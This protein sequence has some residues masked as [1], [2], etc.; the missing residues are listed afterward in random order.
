[1]PS[2]ILSITAFGIHGRGL[3]IYWKYWLRGAMCWECWILVYNIRFEWIWSG[4][5]TTEKL[6]DAIVHY[7]R[8]K[9]SFHETCP[10]LIRQQAVLYRKW[11]PVDHRPPI[12]RLKR[13]MCNTTGFGQA[14]FGMKIKFAP[15]SDI[16]NFIA[17]PNFY[18]WCTALRYK[19]LCRFDTN[20]IICV[21]FLDTY[22]IIKNSVI[23]RWRNSECNGQIVANDFNQDEGIP[24][25]YG[26]NLELMIWRAWHSSLESNQ[27][28]V[29]LVWVYRLRTHGVQMACQVFLRKSYCVVLPFKTRRCCWYEW[30]RCTFQ[31]GQKWFQHIAEESVLLEVDR[32]KRVKHYSSCNY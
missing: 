20:A 22:S 1:M 29:L 31:W 2:V 16:S 10:T 5:K 17:A 9:H 3:T 14:Y 28:R 18:L 27:M 24:P 8:S 6:M 25:V 15:R 30:S 7:T 21:G 12:S 13:K 19:A 23:K 4:T 26:I 32:C 11:T